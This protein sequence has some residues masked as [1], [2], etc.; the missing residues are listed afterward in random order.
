MHIDFPS[1]PGTGADPLAMI[2]PRIGTGRAVHILIVD[3]DAGIREVGARLLLRSGFLVDVAEDGEGA[4]QAMHQRRYDLILTDQNMPHLSGSELI[5]RMREAGVRVPVILMSGG[6][7]EPS[8]ERAAMPDA[9]LT[10]P[11]SLIG[12][13]GEINRQ[14]PVG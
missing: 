4:W 12:L 1:S 2:S 7:T 5:V 10:K 11:F 13:I 3:D 6:E 9:F 8:G 14:L